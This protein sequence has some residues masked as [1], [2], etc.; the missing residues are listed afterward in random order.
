MNTSMMFEFVHQ[1]TM[2]VHL[3]TIKNKMPFNSKISSEGPVRTDPHI[4]LAVKTLKL[5]NYLFLVLTPNL[6]SKVLY[7]S[8][9]HLISNQQGQK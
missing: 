6:V 1:I 2:L 3:V 8:E 7:L 5:A 4:A 9:C